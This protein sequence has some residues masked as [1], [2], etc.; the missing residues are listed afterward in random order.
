AG[1][2]KAAECACPGCS[3]LPTSEVNERTGA[4]LSFVVE[5]R[6]S[7]LKVENRTSRDSQL[8]FSPPYNQPRV[9]K[10]RYHTDDYHA[11]DN[12]PNNSARLQHLFVS[13]NL[14]TTQTNS[15]GITS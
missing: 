1:R 6:R 5:M 2:P 9:K 8:D 7:H 14:V 3:L 10:I 12:V 13:F 4:A 11:D 15:S